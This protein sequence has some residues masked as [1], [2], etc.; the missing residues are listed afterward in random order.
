M[1]V[2][3]RGPR[4]LRQTCCPFR[5]REFRSIEDNGRRN[6]SWL[7]SGD[8]ELY[9]EI[10]PA[11]GFEWVFVKDPE[12]HAVFVFNCKVLA[13]LDEA[14]SGIWRFPNSDRI[15]HVETPVLIHS[16]IQGA[17]LLRLPQRNSWTYASLRFAQKVKEAGLKGL[18]F[19]QVSVS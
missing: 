4:E 13:A 19:R 11:E 16:M 7:A 8:G 12:D 1:Q 17:D 5:L 15:M 18:R 3:S 9:F 10:G 6:G 14:K 2:N